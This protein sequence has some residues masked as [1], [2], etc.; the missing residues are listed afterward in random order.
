MNYHLHPKGIRFKRRNAS[1]TAAVDLIAFLAQDNSMRCNG[2]HSWLDVNKASDDYG[3]WVLFNVA[4][5]TTYVQKT[6]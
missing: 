1:N 3:K 4:T 2:W 6:A 5:K